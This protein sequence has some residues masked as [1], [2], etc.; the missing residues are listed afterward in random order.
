MTNTP[1]TAELIAWHEGGYY[2]PGAY[3]HEA[4]MHRATVEA[5]N[6]IAALKAE[7]EAW[8]AAY[9]AANTGQREANAKLARRWRRWETFPYSGAEC[10]VNP[11]RSM[12]PKNNG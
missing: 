4:A 9:S 6:E 11:Q 3:K 7:V 12:L 2:T 10:S 1:T 5:L 8:K